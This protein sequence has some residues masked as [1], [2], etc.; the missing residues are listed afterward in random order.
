MYRI[1][2]TTTL[3]SKTLSVMLL[4]PRAFELCTWN[5]LN[6]LGRCPLSGLDRPDVGRQARP[7]K[8][9]LAT[10]NGQPA[11]APAALTGTRECRS[12]L[13]ALQTSNQQ[14]YDPLQFKAPGHAAATATAVAYR[15]FSP[16]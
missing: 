6:R 12:S 13:S 5:V 9:D 16:A 15:T 2:Q 3:F 1:S 11:T 8:P 7:S 4:R 10:S 14:R